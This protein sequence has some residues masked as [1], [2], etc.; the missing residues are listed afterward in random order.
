MR[1][2]VH[3]TGGS[4]ARIDWVDYAERNRTADPV[5]CARDVSARAG[6]SAIWLVWL[7]GYRTYEGQCESLA[8]ALT[9]LRGDSLDLVRPDISYFEPA[10]LSGFAPIRQPG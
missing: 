4:P 7:S 8:L 6:S 10:Q 5:A 1:Q 2:E 9:T 3:P